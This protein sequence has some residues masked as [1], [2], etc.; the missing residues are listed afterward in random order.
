MLHS[1]DQR[2]VGVKSRR[3]NILVLS[4]KPESDR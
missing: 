1:L 2:V 4:G 3:D